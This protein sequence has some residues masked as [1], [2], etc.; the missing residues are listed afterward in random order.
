MMVMM[1]A[2]FYLVGVILA[3]AYFAMAYCRDCVESIASVLMS[4]LWP[5]ILL[6]GKVPEFD[7]CCAN[8]GACLVDREEPIRTFLETFGD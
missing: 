2:V 6:Y 4:F 1:L 5:L 8:C 7:G 3:N